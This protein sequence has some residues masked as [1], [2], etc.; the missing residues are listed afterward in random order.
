MNDELFELLR[1]IDTRL[2][3]LE[4]SHPP[5][6]P[7]RKP[8][9]FIELD[10]KPVLAAMAEKGWSP[11]DL[12][13]QIWGYKINNQGKRTAI[14]KDRISVWL[15]GKNRMSRKNFDLL[16]QFVDVV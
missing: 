15:S 12:A 7:K 4:E 5:K 14:G 16:R 3:R 2:K 6:K 8:K 9:P 1:S 11:S 10:P 13:G